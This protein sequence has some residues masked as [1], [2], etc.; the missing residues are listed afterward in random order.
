MLSSDPS[1]MTEVLGSGKS[2]SGFDPRT[3]A[4]CCLWL[5]S[6]DS[7]TLF[8]DAAGTTPAT[9]NGAVAFWKDK[10]S[11]NANVSNATSAQQPTYT[12][13]GLSFSG[14]Q[15][16]TSTSPSF[17]SGGAAGFVV[18]NPP[19]ITSRGRLFRAWSNTY[20]V[21]IDTEYVD[22]SIPTRYSYQLTKPSTGVNNIFSVVAYSPS[23]TEWSTNFNTSTTWQY[24][25]FTGSSVS[26]PFIEI[27]AISGYPLTGTISE[28]ILYDSFLTVSQKQAIEAYLTW[29]WMPTFDAASAPTSLSGCKLW[30]DGSDPAGTGTP[31]ADGS[32]VSTWVDKSSNYNATVVSGKIG[33]T[34]NASTRSVYFSASNMA[35]ITSY[36]AN[37]TNETMFVVFNNPTANTNNYA[38]IDGQSGARAL[39]AGWNGTGTNDAVAY[40][41]NE[42]AWATKT[43]SNSH[44]PGTVTLVTGQVVS[45]TNLRIAINGATFSTG[46]VTA[47]SST[48]GTY[49]GVNANTANPIAY[50]Y[51][52]Y[53]MEIIFYD[54]VLTT[55]ERI[56]V[57]N[58]LKRKWTI[59]ALPNSHLFNLVT[60]YTRFFQPTDLRDCYCWVDAAQDR[61]TLGSSIS[62]LPDLSGNAPSIAPL[63]GTITLQANGLNGLP[64]YNFGTSRA[65]SGPTFTWNSSFTQFA[66][67]QCAL[68]YWMA[69]NL[70]PANNSY[71]NYIY[72]GNWGLYYDTVINVNDGTMPPNVGNRS[73]FEYAAGGK[74]SWLI[75]CLGH[76]SGDSNLTNY[77]VNGIVLSSTT[78]TA[79]SITNLGKLMLNGNGSANTDTTKV[80][81]FIH[82]NRS[83]SQAERQQVEGYL[84]QKWGL[85]QSLGFSLLPTLLVGCSLWLD[86]ADKSSASMTFSSGSNL[87]V[88]KDKSGNSR[89]FSLT[90]GTPI[91]IV[92]YGVNVVSFP[93]SSNTVMTSSSTFAIVNASSVFIVCK[94]TKGADFAMALGFPSIAGGDYSIR[95]ANGVLNGTAASAGNINDIGN[96]VYYVNGT[97]NP[98]LGSNAYL[99]QYVVISSLTFNSNGTTAVSVSASAYG[100]YFEGTIA[101][102]LLFEAGVTTTQRTQIENYLMEKWKVIPFTS[103]TVDGVTPFVPTIFSGCKLWLDGADA[104]TLSFSSGSNISTWTDKSGNSNTASAYTGTVVYNASDKA[105]YFSGG[106][107]LSIPLVTNVNRI[108]SGFFVVS[109]AS[110][111]SVSVIQGTTVDKGRIFRSY[112]NQL[113]TMEQNTTVN[114]SS[115]TTLANQRML[116]GYIDDGT[117]VTHSINNSLMIQLVTT[118]VGDF[119]SAQILLGYSS[120]GESMIGYIYEAMIFNTVL[121][122]TQRQQIVDFL[123]Q[124]WNIDRSPYSFNPTAIPGCYT[125]LDA[126]DSTTTTSLSSG[127][128]TDKSGFGRNTTSNVGGGTFTLSNIRGVPA[129]QFPGT[130]GTAAFKLSSISLPSTTGF[131]IFMV[132]NPTAIGSGGTRIL[133][134]NTGGFQV[135]PNSATYPAKIGIYNGSSFDTTVSYP[136]NSPIAFSLTVQSNVFSIWSNG[137]LGGRP[138]LGTS[139]V[140]S[141]MIGNYDGGPGSAYALLGQLGEVIIYS[142]AVS[143]IAR[144]QIEKYLLS[145]WKIEPAIGKLIYH[146]YR[147][148][149]PEVPALFT[150]TTLSRCQLWLDGMD[151]NG[152]GVRPSTGSTISRWIDKSGNV[153]NAI[154]VGSGTYLSGGG[155]NFDN[156]VYFSN[157]TLK[158]TLANRSVFFVMQEG[159][160]GTGGI[161]LFLQS[162]S[163]TGYDYDQASAIPYYTEAGNGFSVFTNWYAT[164]RFGYVTKFGNTTLLPKAIYNDNMNTAVGSGYLNGS[165]ATNNVATAPNTTCS[166]YMIGTRWFLNAPATSGNRFT[167]V[168]YE[169]IAYDRGLTN[170]ERQQVEGYL[171]WKWNLNSSLPTNHPFYKISPSPGIRSIMLTTDELYLWLDASDLSTLYQ[172]QTVTTPVTASGQSVRLWIDKS[173]KQRNYLSVFTTYPSY[174]T[175]SQ[176]PEVECDANNKM[177][178]CTTLPAGCRGLDVF[179]V[180]RPL[181]TTADWRT[182]FRGNTT[183]H[184]VIIQNGSYNLGAFY[185]A[186]NTFYQFGSL[187]L[188]GSRRVVLHVSFATGGAQSGSITALG[189]AY[190]GN[191]VMS[192]ASSTNGNDNFYFLGGY[193]GSQPW[194]YISEV[195]VFRRNLANQEKI[196]VFNYLNSKWFTRLTVKNAIDYLP[197][198]TDTTNLGTNPQTVTNIGSVTFTTVGG[199][200]CAYFPNSFGTYLRFPYTNP[201]K[202]TICFWLRPGDATYYTAISLTTEALSTAIIALQVDTISSTQLRVYT[203]MPNQWTNQPTG[204]STV[205]GW[206]HYAVTVNQITFVEELYVNGSRVDSVT[207]TGSSLSR[208]DRWVLGRSGDGSRAFYGHMRQFAVF[209]TILTPYEVLDIYNAS[210]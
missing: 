174:S 55:T 52:G 190:D 77:T 203:A 54:R 47:F 130:A 170:S 5:D 73:I 16:L 193:V 33:A 181:T 97:L 4:K 161:F 1:I 121:T 12:S 183:D 63:G 39:G 36:P 105:V 177:F 62:T 15:T 147:S 58:Y 75:L 22:L 166:G 144:D 49:L 87:S 17:S 6:S 162:P 38:L 146:P 206:T 46:T 13:T 182:L 204:A 189:Q 151:T 3:V 14:G 180:T 8:S 178:Q 103:N 128:W 137:I 129:I 7:N 157:T 107:G 173:G 65:M 163:N 153:N 209:T 119:P 59:L 9:L 51:T 31:P 10:S 71:Y 41:N 185:N 98:N 192:A 40:L 133:S 25:T 138:T 141:L 43:P 155:V 91:S 114:F 145:K 194:G 201:E 30:L 70:V 99:N 92:D 127:I 126:A 158:M 35:Y 148:V 186:A 134:G 18:F 89:N 169:I 61:T 102:V 34:Y 115:G 67:V 116:V 208:T 195:L 82:Y 88:W 21:S 188:D 57:E 20:L 120:S 117:T 27:G 101:E 139:T 164:N 156:T 108:Q 131:S 56:Y 23:N 72:S 175:K 79:S 125:W 123:S 50:Y 167:G 160:H 122:S 106:V 85:S 19:S 191:V 64:V 187:T 26:I 28:I 96:T 197:L 142:N 80:A 104:S 86:G 172:T 207:G 68:G 94:L 110:A 118:G 100:R 159:V 135:Y 81:E 66:V 113:Q 11:A 83:L 136:S 109:L 150:P 112:N 198:A 37:P 32:T 78:S 165:N 168:H 44:V 154:G 29:K 53:A 24:T 143:S 132:F 48:A 2:I 74:T 140:T 202:F 199:Y 210:I 171:A 200:A 205:N 42:V 179:V 93:T 69:A 196:E 149:R 184:Q 176:V 95:F 90:S 76:R 60:P 124:K 152:T 84:A 111:A 45:S